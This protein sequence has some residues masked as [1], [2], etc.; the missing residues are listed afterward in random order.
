M[1]AIDLTR[2][3]QQ[4]D[5]LAELY[6]DPEAFQDE[7]H[8]ILG[9]YHRYSHKQQQESMPKSFMRHYDLPEKVL[10]HLEARL[11]Y[12]SKAHPDEILRLVDQLWTDDY[13]ETRDLSTNLIGDIPIEYKE[14]VLELIDAWLE[15]PLDRAVI[16]AIFTKATRNLLKEI[17]DEW[18]HL[19][20][21]LLVDGRSH[22]QKIG[23]EAMAYLVPKSSGDDLPAYFRWI[24]PF[25]ISQDQTLDNHLLKVVSALAKHSQQ[26]T[27]YLLREVLADSDDAHIASRIRRYLD[28]FEEETQKKLLVALKN[29]VLLSKNQTK[30]QGNS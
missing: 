18:K 27:A 26:E 12:L 1:A 5:K 16:E 15:Q 21:R 9:F 28:F 13:F 23:L 25:L 4:I 11:K 29:Q 14:Q 30:N 6:Q 24:R 8:A 10:P 20:D 22:Q 19:I 2:L 3:N 17:P 7:F